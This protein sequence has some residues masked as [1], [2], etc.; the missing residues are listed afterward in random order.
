[1]YRLTVGHIYFYRCLTLELYLSTYFL[2]IIFRKK[3]VYV[4]ARTVKM[5]IARM[6]T[7]RR[8]EPSGS[9]GLM[10]ASSNF[11]PIKETMAMVI[12]TIRFIGVVYY[13]STS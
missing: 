7:I 3:S 10:K 6:E 2:D 12:R 11:A 9:S 13:R 8:F 5:A 1:M 4:V